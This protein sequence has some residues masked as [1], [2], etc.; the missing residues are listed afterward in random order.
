LGGEGESN[1]LALR[2]CSGKKPDEREWKINGGGR[3]AVSLLQEK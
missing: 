1:P 2:E 3:S